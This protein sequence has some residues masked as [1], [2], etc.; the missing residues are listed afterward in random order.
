[1]SNTRKE[2][3]I[4]VL[5]KQAEKEMF[6]FTMNEKFYTVNSLVAM[7]LSSKIPALVKL[8]KKF[9]DVKIINLGGMPVLYLKVK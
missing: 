1:M 5:R 7:G 2:D 9:K 3:P 8:N 4:E 6:Q